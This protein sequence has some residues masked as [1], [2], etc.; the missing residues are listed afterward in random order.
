MSIVSLSTHSYNFPQVTGQLEKKERNLLCQ[1]IFPILLV[2]FWASIAHDIVNSL[3]IIVI[4]YI[5]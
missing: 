1:K 4:N 5:R 2:K 3:N